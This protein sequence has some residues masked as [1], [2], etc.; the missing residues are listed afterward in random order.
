MQL[1]YNA[2]SRD[3]VISNGLHEQIFKIMH[4]PWVNVHLDKVTV[5]TFFIL[6]YQTNALLPLSRCLTIQF[7]VTHSNTH[8]L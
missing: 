2:T 1:T 3:P 7:N 8:T 6:R 4:K 5:E